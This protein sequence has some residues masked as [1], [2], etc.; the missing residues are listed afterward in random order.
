VKSANVTGIPN[1]SLCHD[2]IPKMYLT[3]LTWD[4]FQNLSSDAEAASV[5][6]FCLFS[7]ATLEI[8]CSPGTADIAMVE[9]EHPDAWRWA[10][11]SP[12]GF[13]IDGGSEPTHA[14]AR[15][16]VE[17]ALRLEVASVTAISS[18]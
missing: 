7:L 3:T 5:S 13:I 2:Q 12:D 17:Q 8:A 1:P 18:G 11:I 9:Q 4:S 15:K 10:I 6:K 16:A 14:H